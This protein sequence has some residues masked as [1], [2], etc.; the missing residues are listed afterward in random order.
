VPVIPAF[1]EAEAGKSKVE[2]SLGYTG[3]PWF[4]MARP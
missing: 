1:R 2:A 4:K 3:R